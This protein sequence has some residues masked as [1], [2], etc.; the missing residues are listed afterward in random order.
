MPSS[1][2]TIDDSSV[3]HLLRSI[4]N[5]EQAAGPVREFIGK[6]DQ[7]WNAEQPRAPEQ[8]PRQ[9]GRFRLFELLG[10]GGFGLVYL[11]E[12]TLS[13]KKVALKLPR[14][15]KYVRPE[16]RERF[17]REARAA[18]VL[19]HPNIVRVYDVGEIDGQWYIST[20]YCPGLNLAQWLATHQRS[21][22][23]TEAAQLLCTLAGAMAHAHERGVIHRDLKPS[24][25]LLEPKEGSALFS[26]AEVTP[27]IADFG[28]AKLIEESG[29][30]T[31]SGVLL[32]TLQYMAPEQ[33]GMKREEV[34]PATDIYALGL[35]LY[36]VLTRQPVIP[37]EPLLLSLPKILHNTAPRLRS[38]RSDCPVD[39][40]TIYL[41][42]L[43]K[44]PRQRYVSAQALHDD[45]KRF[46]QGQSIVARPGMV[47]RLGSWMKREPVFATILLFSLLTMMLVLGGVLYHSHETEQS[48]QRIRAAL[49]RTQQLH[50][51]STIQRAAQLTQSGEGAE[52]SQLLRR[53]RDELLEQETPL[54]W[55]WRYLWN[56]VQ[57]MPRHYRWYGHQETPY[58]LAYSP[59][60]NWVATGDNLGV[61]MIRHADTGKVIKTLQS[62]KR[63]SPNLVFSEDGR[64][65][66]QICGDDHAHLDTALVWDTSNWSI[67]SSCSISNEILT[68]LCFQPQ[69]PTLVLTT[70]C[71]VSGQESGR[72][73]T[74]DYLEAQA[75]PKTV[76]AGDRCHTIWWSPVLQSYLLASELEF[77]SLD[78]Q[79]H[80]RYFSPGPHYIIRAATTSRD[81]RWFA[82]GDFGG[83]IYLFDGR[84]S[85]TEARHI[86]NPHPKWIFHLDFH[87]NSTLLASCGLGNLVQ[88]WDVNTAKLAYQLQAKGN[89]IGAVFAK[90]GNS[91]FF[92]SS[93][94]FSVN[95]WYFADNSRKVSQ[96]QL[97]DQ[98]W[99]LALA[100]DG[101]TLYAGLDDIHSKATI[102]QLVPSQSAWSVPGKYSIHGAC[103]IGILP[104][105]QEGRVISASMDGA[106]ALL[107]LKTNTT[108]AKVTT[109]QGKGVRQLIEMEPGKSVATCGHDGLVRLWNHQLQPLGEPLNAHDGK[110]VRD[111]CYDRRRQQLY[112]SGNDS[113][114]VQWD[115]K[116]Q[117][118]VRVL[119]ADS[120]VRSLCLSNDG[121][122]LAYG[123]KLGEI[124]LVSLNDWQV[125]RQFRSHEDPVT[126]LLFSPDDRSLISGDF[127]GHLY[128]WNVESGEQLL[129]LPD[130]QNRI[131]TLLWSK[132]GSKLYSASLDGRIVEHDFR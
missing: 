8:L 99:C 95:R 74:W 28:L 47:R 125:I 117:K 105:E 20:S 15:E 114:I 56:R 40:E 121:N 5:H 69:Q 80:D 87:P 37:A 88:L 64:W 84:R 107:D 66:A 52:A 96:T 39:L 67:R 120:E 32:G 6:A 128:L 41:K 61:L 129:K 58:A 119:E 83:K 100:P 48:N 130:H 85:W 115:V 75:T 31:V 33:A 82:W 108:L 45:L 104:L 16:W 29:A 21:V 54:T 81:G 9:L 132:D 89:T 1:A 13:G 3:E 68:S 131:T 57:L 35:I 118:L 116:T 103:V 26:L 122:Y 110:P 7:F 93:E 106:L 124:F 50:Y 113:R 43:E 90:D 36:E 77:K 53:C 24:N 126:E 76:L 19:T 91:V 79:F 12:E 30:H 60:Q 27:C 2:Q 23:V 44:N 59:S 86:W 94:D 25:I 102:R 46:L 42:C 71:D 49:H 73:I 10:E 38:A 65:L 111:L 112:S 70:R 109:H 101:Q 63:K 17:L 127:V 22:E 55:E 34:G 14:P 62:P 4:E 92:T 72:V 78:E 97:G 98:V 123:T 18:A 51:L 11:A